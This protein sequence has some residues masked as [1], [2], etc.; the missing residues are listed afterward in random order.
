[1]IGL[2]IL[3]GFAAAVIT[4]VGTLAI[5]HQLRHPPRNTYAKAM[6]HDNPIDPADLGL[7]ATEFTF[8]LSN[9]A[10]SPGWLIQG[11]DQTSGG[12]GGA[13]LIIVTHGWGESRVSVLP[14]VPMLA[15]LARAVVVYDLRAH[16]DSTAKRSDLGTTEVDDL[17]AIVDQL[18]PALGPVVFY[19]CSIGAGISIAAAAQA[20]DSATGQRIRGVIGEGV[21][22]LGM[23]PIYG[24]FHIRDWPTWPF[25]WLVGLHLNFWVK[26]DSLFDR[27]RH[28]ARLRCPLLLLH[29]MADHI[30]PIASARAIAAA[31]PKDGTLDRLR[32]RRPHSIKQSSIP[33]V[34][35][36]ALTTFLQ[37][38]RKFDRAAD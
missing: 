12:G 14:V 6:A 15:G 36:D 2:L 33:N 28:A 32:G 8:R 34:Y 30:T 19:G 31:A 7:A 20:P 24:F 29:G 11:Q 10:T 35:L 1:M 21:Y 18:E 16:G 3:F 26:R 27:A 13:P 25:L 4:A 17:L 37:R 5:I 23:E 22:R 38:V 9:G